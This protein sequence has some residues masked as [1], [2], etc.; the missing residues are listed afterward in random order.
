MREGRLEEGGKDVGM[1]LGQ[2]GPPN[3]RAALT[4]GTVEATPSAG[5]DIR[6]G[7]EHGGLQNK[8]SRI[9]RAASA[10]T[11]GGPVDCRGGGPREVEGGE[12]APYPNGW[13]RAV[14]IVAVNAA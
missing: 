1:R 13:E 4:V 11:G 6:Y 2:G 12:R 10:W 7:N 8:H 14:R 5:H 3:R 9:W